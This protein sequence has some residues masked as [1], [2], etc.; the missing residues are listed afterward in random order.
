MTTTTTNGQRPTHRISYEVKG[1][2]GKT[3]RDIEIGAIWAPRGNGP[4]K[5]KFDVPPPAGEFLSAWPITE[6]EKAA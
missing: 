3:V 1:R 5:I 4:Q 6:K 2:D